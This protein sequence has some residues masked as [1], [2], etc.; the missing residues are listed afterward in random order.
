MRRAKQQ[1]V[2]ALLPHLSNL[3]KFF[4]LEVVIV[5]SETGLEVI[6]VE[7]N[8]TVL[9]RAVQ[10]FTLVEDYRNTV[11]V[12][13]DRW[14]RAFGI[15]GIHRHAEPLV[16]RELQRSNKILLYNFVMHHI[17]LI[18]IVGDTIYCHCQCVH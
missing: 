14:T 6:H 9:K 5:N 10:E 4:Q 16:E 12:N 8:A 2:Y 13:G 18:L 7:A 17:V 11:L 1:R 3:R 15:V